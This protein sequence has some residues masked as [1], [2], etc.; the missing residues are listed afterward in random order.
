MIIHEAA[1]NYLEAIYMIRIRKGGCRSIDVAN[2]LG[3]SKPTGSVMMKNLRESE[4]INVD[5]Q[6]DI[7]LNECG[8]EIARKMYERHELIAA[9][10]IALGVSEENAYRDS[11]RIEHDMSAETFEAVKRYITTVLKERNGL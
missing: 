5:A 4:Y 9:A 7:T 8:L 6:G 10:L 11:C 3:Y 1:E 2:E